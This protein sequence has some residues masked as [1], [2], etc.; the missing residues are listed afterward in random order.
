MLGKISAFIKRDF[1]IETSYRFSFML[2]FLGIFFSAAGF[3][4]LAK[5]FGKNISP[6]LEPYGGDYF[7]FVL[8]GIAISS[9]LATSMRSF[10]SSISG[11]QLQG[12]L[13]SI[14]ITPTRISEIVL[15]SS[16]WNFIS[17]AFDI[18][19]YL[20]IGIVI[21]GL[22]LNLANY[23]AAALVLVLTIVCFSGLGIISAS[24]IMLLKR[25][26]P[27][28]WVVA[29]VSSFLGGTFFPIAVFPAWLQKLAYL[30]PLFYS[31]RAMR[32][33]LLKGYSF[34]A[35]RYDV[36]ALVV[37][38]IAILPL[39]IFSFKHAVRVAKTEGSLGTY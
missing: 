7:S 17:T 16:I 11:A 3:F 19:V 10:S 14:L 26:D 22:R 35:L 32:L 6:Y 13:E 27:I 21:F 36:T 15:Y 2:R 38:I 12:T 18:L 37:F 33:A 31:L 20:V 30:F 25:G 8:I 23:A 28:S 29:S 24:F 1:L 4:F 39:S 9:F 34:Y 5:L